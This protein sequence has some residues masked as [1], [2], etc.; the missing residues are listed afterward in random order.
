MPQLML[1]PYTQ[2]F[3]SKNLIVLIT[4]IDLCKCIWIFDADTH[5]QGGLAIRLPAAQFL[6]RDKLSSRPEACWQSLLAREAKLGP[7]AW[8][9]GKG[10]DALR[11]LR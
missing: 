4:D 1:L 10:I 2:R 8:A 7:C 6:N 5:V 11:W 9:A 3:A